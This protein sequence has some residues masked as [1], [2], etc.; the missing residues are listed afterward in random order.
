MGLDIEFEDDDAMD[1]DLGDKA[2]NPDVG[3]YVDKA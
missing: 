2:Y 3:D 1:P